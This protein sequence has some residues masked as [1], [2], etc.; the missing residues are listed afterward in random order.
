MDI[1]GA[2]AEMVNGWNADPEADPPVEGRC[3]FCW[4]F[5]AP[6]RESD[7]N[8]YQ[9][10]GDGCCVLVALTDFR[11]DCSAP[12]N[13]RSGTRALGSRVWNFNLHF[14]A[15]D[16]LGLNVYDEIPGHPLAE[17]KWSTILNPLYECVACSPLDFCEPLGQ[18]LEVTRWSATPRIDW[19]DNNYTGWTVQV[20]LR[21]NNVA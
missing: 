17:S 11:F 7:L 13:P 2:I 21:Q 8:E 18:A 5:T 1:V 9:F 10:R 3:G 12:F 14:L 19:Q 16:D 6:I 15:V 20:A 4:E